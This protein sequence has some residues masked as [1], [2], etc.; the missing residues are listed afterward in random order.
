MKNPNRLAVILL[1]C[2]LLDGEAMTLRADCFDPSHGYTRAEAIVRQGRIFAD[3]RSAMRTLPGLT[4][5]QIDQ[6]ILQEFPQEYS[7]LTDAILQEL[8]EQAE[9]GMATAEE[10]AWKAKPMPK[11]RQLDAMR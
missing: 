5:Q 4:D 3:L 1:F 10:R 8:E 2:M 11:V 6:V 9:R 7:H